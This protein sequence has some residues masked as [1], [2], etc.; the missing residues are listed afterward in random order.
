MTFASSADS[1]PA[2]W[3]RLPQDTYKARSKAAATDPLVVTFTASGWPRGGGVPLGMAAHVENGDDLP[4]RG[5]REPLT[6][7]F[8]FF[9][10]SRVIFL[11]P[12]FSDDFNISSGS[13]LR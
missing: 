8:R 4:L 9:V 2:G 12:T 5:I 1:L 6:I 7:F 10:R 11:R 13:G 3:Y